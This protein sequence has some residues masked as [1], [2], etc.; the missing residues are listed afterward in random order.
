MDLPVLH[1]F[2]ILLR[3]YTPS[4]FQVFARLMADPDFMLHTGGPMSE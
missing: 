2:R 3:P 4:D 1:G